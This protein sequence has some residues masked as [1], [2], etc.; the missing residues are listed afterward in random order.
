MHIPLFLSISF[1][2]LNNCS[3]FNS[4]WIKTSQAAPVKALSKS[5]GHKLIIFWYPP[6]ILAQAFSINKGQK[7]KFDGLIKYNTLLFLIQGKKSSIYTILNSLSI[8]KII[9][10]IPSDVYSLFNIIL[11][12]IE[13]NLFR[14]INTVLKYI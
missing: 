9:L 7:E 6:L 13:G 10:Y 2:S 12:N 1:N 5:H 8:N 3:Q 14:D 11:L 4:S